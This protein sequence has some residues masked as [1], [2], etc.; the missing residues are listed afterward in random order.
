MLGRYLSLTVL[1]AFVV[2]AT[3]LAGSFEAGEWYYV[4]LTRPA[5][6]PPPWAFGAAWALVYLLLALAAWQVWLSG[7]YARV[8]ALSWWALL[9][10]LGV[11]WSALFFGLHRIGWSSGVLLIAAAVA[12]QCFRVFRP[13]APQAAWLLTPYLAWTL[14]L[15]ALN[16]AMWTLNGGP[17]GRF[18]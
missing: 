3:W 6:T 15:A 8:A 7:H 5:W 16:L 18:L 17:L 12:L 10:I 1:L 9:P 11:A 2:L 13:L 14:F 4:N